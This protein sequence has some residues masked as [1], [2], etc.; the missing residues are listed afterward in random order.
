[1]TIFYAATNYAKS[2]KLVGNAVGLGIVT[3]QQLYG[4]DNVLLLHLLAA[5][6]LSHCRGAMVS[7]YSME[8]LPHK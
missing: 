2:L 7:I 6:G 5:L 8:I 4:E 1:M 3:V